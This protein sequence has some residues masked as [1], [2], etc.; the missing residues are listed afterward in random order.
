VISASLAMTVPPEDFSGRV[1]IFYPGQEP[2]QEVLRG[3]EMELA[4]RVDIDSVAPNYFRTLG[5][6]LLQGRDF[7]ERDDEAAVPRDQDGNELRIGDCRSSIEDAKGQS[8][9]DTAGR[10][11]NHGKSESRCL[12]SPIDN[13][14]SAIFNAP[15]VVI[16]S[17]K[18]AEHLWPGENP[19]GK[20]ISWPSMVGPPRPPLEVV[21]ETADSKYRSLVSDAPL[22]MYVPLFQNYD[23]R[24][25]IVV[26]TASAPSGVSTAVRSAIASLDKNLPV[27]GVKTMPQQIAFSLWQQ[28]MAASLISAFGLLALTLAAIG[29]YGVVAHSV[30]QRT[31]EIGIRVALGAAH[32]DVLRL[33]VGEGMVLALLGVAVGLAVAVSLLPLTRLMPSLLYGV[34]SNDPLTYAAIAALLGG[35]SLAAS[36]FPAR[37]AARVDPV[38]ALRQE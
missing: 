31:H 12:Q 30:A 37:R 10:Q 11:D 24:P 27:F 8:T 34:R 32:N 35:V 38:V 17:H 22:L 4:L 18:L 13:R 2:R 29:L 21:G 5:I 36:Y 25:T 33:V 14:Q 28:R 9:A 3:H 6:P 23:G 7:T 19:I 26:R 1:S 15:G 16:V 20:R